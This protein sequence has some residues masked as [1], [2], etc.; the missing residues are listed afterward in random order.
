[1]KPKP[2]TLT[3]FSSAGIGDPWHYEVHNVREYIGNYKI[4][5]SVG[6][7]SA[8]GNDV[9]ELSISAPGVVQETNSPGF[10]HIPCLTMIPGVTSG[11][12]VLYCCN[13][14]SGPITVEW[15]NPC[16]GVL[17]AT[18]FKDHSIQLHF[19]PF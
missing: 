15:Q 5:V 1:M 4:T 10:T 17:N 7:I 18:N 13:R 6:G 16:T 3:I 8:A 2:F 11:T 12:G 9:V 19:E 14:F